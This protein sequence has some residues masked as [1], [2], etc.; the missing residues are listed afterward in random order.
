MYFYLCTHPHTHI[1]STGVL[2]VLVCWECVCLPPCTKRW[3]SYGEE[4]S[5]SLPVFSKRLDGVRKN[6]GKYRY[7]SSSRCLGP[8]LQFRISVSQPL[9]VLKWTS[10]FSKD[11]PKWTLLLGS[12]VSPLSFCPMLPLSWTG[13]IL[14]KGLCPWPS[15]YI[16]CYLLFSAFGYEVNRQK[17]NL[18]ALYI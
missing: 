11:K 2:E 9:L 12:F 5:S 17:A 10:W 4:W 13:C 16:Q 3:L 1:C 6:S 15:C 7:V 8:S 14:W 18:V